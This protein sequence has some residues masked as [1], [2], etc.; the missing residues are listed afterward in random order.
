MKILVLSDSHGDE[1]VIEQAY[2]REKPDEVIFLGDGIRDIEFFSCAYPS[3]RVSVV[4]GNCDFFARNGEEFVEKYGDV[5]VFACHG[6]AYGV[7]IGTANIVCTAKKKGASIAL[8]GH[9]HDPFLGERENVTLFNPGS[10]RNER[11]GIINVENGS[12]ECILKCL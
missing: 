8:F 2:E 12:F 9:T 5:T 6:H 11:Y 3:A 7:K 1:S 4:R 10:I